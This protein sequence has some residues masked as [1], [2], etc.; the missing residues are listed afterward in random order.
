MVAIGIGIDEQ[1]RRGLTFHSW[2]HFSNSAIRGDIADSVL[3]Q[4]MGH[5][6]VEMTDRYYHMTA[7]QGESYRKSVKTNI[8]PIVFGVLK[9]A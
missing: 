6:S 7:D 3:Q 8:I 5:S 9:T 1:K 4:A 2:R